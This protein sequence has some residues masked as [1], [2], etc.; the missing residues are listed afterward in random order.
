ME[1]LAS[2]GRRIMV[3]APQFG[4]KPKPSLANNLPFEKQFLACPLALSEAKHLTMDYEVI[5]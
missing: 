4:S 3:E 2:P 1:P 5:I